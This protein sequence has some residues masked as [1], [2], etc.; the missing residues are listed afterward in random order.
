M[1]KTTFNIAKMDCPSE[2]QM[3]RMKL[4]DIDTIVSLDFDI[5][6]RRLDVVHTGEHQPIL[7]RLETLN[8]DTTWVESVPYDGANANA[9]GTQDKA[10]NNNSNQRKLLWQVLAINLLF[11]VLEMATGLVSQSMGLIADSLDMLADSVVY[12]L[13]LIAVGGSALLKKNIA[14]SAGVLQLILAVMGL[15]EVLRR[16]LGVEDAPAFAM[17]IGMSAL[18]LVGNVVCLYLLQKSQ[19]KEAHMQ[20]SMIFTSNDVVVNLGVI[21]AG[22]LVYVTESKYPDLLVGLI[23]FGL[24]AMGAVRIFRLSR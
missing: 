21:L 9:D 12:G 2:E 15:I 4:A 24:P 19:S 5:A 11:F 13:A 18:A 8:F 17:M 14:K 7:A 23:V 1:N 16:F 10:Q 22:V 6:G 20:A 3:I